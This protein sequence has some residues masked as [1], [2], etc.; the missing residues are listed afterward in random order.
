[1]KKTILALGVSTLLA[2]L[3]TTASAQSPLTSPLVVT[4]TNIGHILV[5]PYFTAQEGNATLLNIVNTD[6]MNGKALKVRF[7]GASNSDDVFDFTLFLS[8]GDVWAA[9][10]SQNP[11][12]G[13]A[14][15]STSD[16]SCT[17]PTQVNRDFITARVNPKA[18]TANETR[19]G[20]I[21]I[22]NA[23]DIVP[24]TAV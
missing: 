13:L 6:K 8:P 15:L 17:L 1:M 23:A 16:N 3:A 7:R 12:T 22:L 19:E 9:E 10:I 21:E 11:S 24:G 18:D 2:G 14:R 4:P 20:Y 5:V